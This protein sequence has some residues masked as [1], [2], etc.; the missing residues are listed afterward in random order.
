MDYLIQSS[1]KVGFPFIHSVLN[2]YLRK[3]DTRYT[4][5]LPDV[6]TMLIFHVVVQMLSFFISQRHCSCIVGKGYEENLERL[7]KVGV[8]SAGCKRVPGNCE[9][10]GTWFTITCRSLTSHLKN[11][12]Q[13]LRFPC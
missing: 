7:D 4:S 1:R 11:H 13:L 9:I 10:R 3:E 8:K 5:R 6:H 12:R 2:I